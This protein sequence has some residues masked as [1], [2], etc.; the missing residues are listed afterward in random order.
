MVVKVS[1]LSLS[2]C[3]AFHV[4][5]KSNPVAKLQFIEDKATSPDTPTLCVQKWRVAPTF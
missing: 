1:H 5:P 2:L 3:T 4:S